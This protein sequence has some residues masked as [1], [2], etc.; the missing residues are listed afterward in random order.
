MVS[1][2]EKLDDDA[3]ARELGLVTR[4]L[5]M[6][7]SVQ[8]GTAAGVLCEE[9]T[10]L[11]DYVAARLARCPY[12]AEKPTC[13]QCPVHCYRPA[14]RARIKEVMRVAGPRLLLR[15]DLDAL[16]HLVHDKKK[17]PERKKG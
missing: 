7:C 17:V 1:Y 8:H 14:E 10:A 16:R 5:D 9:C 15:G 2:T 4:M 13:R 11:R 3:M 6:A 12:G